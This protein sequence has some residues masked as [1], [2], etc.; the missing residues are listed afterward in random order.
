MSDVESTFFLAEAIST[1][2][3]AIVATWTVSMGAQRALT[4]RQLLRDTGEIQP[5]LDVKGA[6]M[7]PVGTKL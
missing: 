7:L 4:T 1:A 3:M 2:S 6:M 5:V